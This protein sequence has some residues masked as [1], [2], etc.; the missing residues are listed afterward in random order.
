MNQP[1]ANMSFPV[2]WEYLKTT[3]Q[4]NRARVHGLLALLELILHSDKND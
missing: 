3:D 4:N 2:I 1:L